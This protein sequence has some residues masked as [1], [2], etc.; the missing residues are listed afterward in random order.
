MTELMRSLII[1]GIFGTIFA[2]AE[3]W[4]ILLHGKVEH[5]RKFVHFACGLVALSFSYIFQSHWTVLALCVIFSLIIVTSKRLNLLQSIHGVQR[6]TQGGIYHPIAIYVTFLLSLY[7]QQPL[8]YVI[9]I[10]VLSV[11]DAFAALIGVSYGVNFYKVEKDIKSWEGSTIFFLCT[12]LIVHIS[13]LLFTSTG[14]LESILIGLYA[15]IMVTIIEAISFRGTD[16]LFVPLGTIYVVYLNFYAGAEHLAWQFPMLLGTLALTALI[17]KPSKKFG[18]SGIVAFALFGYTVWTMISWTW[19]IALLIGILAV[20]YSNYFLGISENEDEE[21]RVVPVF[22]M[23]IPAFI[24]IAVT[25]FFVDVLRIDYQAILYVP[26]IICVTSRLVTLWGWRRRKLDSWKWANV[27]LRTLIVTV[28][29]SSTLFFVANQ[30]ILLMAIMMYVG[31]LFI[32]V[33]F[34]L[35]GGKEIEKRSRIWLLRAA[36]I[37]TIVVTAGIALANY[38]LYQLLGS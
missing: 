7:M 37:I 29:F 27:F 24:W 36:A 22:Y 5:T 18:N 14:R 17:A 8:F 12:F 28:V 11:S 10:L 34:W 13:L 21:Y 1:S 30:H 31:T 35:I 6:I 2:I 3:A 9:A 23:L 26:Y 38:Y 19:T 33:A 4:R 16:N 15:A 20:S 25:N 32:Q